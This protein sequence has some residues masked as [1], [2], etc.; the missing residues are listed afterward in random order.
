MSGQG[1]VFG[2]G[3]GGCGDVEGRWELH[4]DRLKKD[5][6]GTICIKPGV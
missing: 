2:W 3:W 4:I 5:K 6:Y 1:F